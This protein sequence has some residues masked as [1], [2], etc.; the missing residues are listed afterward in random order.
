MVVVTPVCQVTLANGEVHTLEG[1]VAHM[2]V[3][4]MEPKIRKAIEASDRGQVYM[5]YI[6]K[7][8]DVQPA[9][10]FKSSKKE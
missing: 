7:A 9:P 2:I 10:M 8:V 4:L 5:H 6:G 1:P 3:R